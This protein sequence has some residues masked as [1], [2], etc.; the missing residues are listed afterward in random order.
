MAEYREQNENVSIDAGNND[1]DIT[2]RPLMLNEADVLEVTQSSGLTVETVDMSVLNTPYFI[3][4]MRWIQDSGDKFA[5]WSPA[6]MRITI[7]P[8]AGTPTNIDVN[9]YECEHLFLTLKTTATSEA[10]ATLFARV[11]GV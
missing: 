4:L 3:D 11:Q 6:S 9:Y 10:T 7:A 8:T 1:I 2:V 5:C